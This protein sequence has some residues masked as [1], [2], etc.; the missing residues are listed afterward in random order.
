M[1][2]TQPVNASTGQLINPQQ[3]QDQGV[4]RFKN[5]S[6]HDMTLMEL[7][8]A[9]GN[10]SNAAFD[11]PF[12]V[13]MYFEVWVTNAGG[14][15]ED[16]TTRH[17]RALY[18]YPEQDANSNHSFSFAPYT[19][20]CMSS[21]QVIYAAPN[22]CPLA[23]WEQYMATRGPMS[24]AGM[25]YISDETRALLDCGP[26][27][28]LSPSDAIVNAQYPT[29]AELNRQMCYNY[30]QM[31]PQWSC[32]RNSGSDYELIAS[33]ASNVP[34]NTENIPYALDQL[35]NNC[36]RRFTSADANSLSDERNK[37][38]FLSSGIYIMASLLGASLICVVVLFVRLVS[39]QKRFR[40]DSERLLMGEEGEGKVNANRE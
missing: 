34:T 29:T 14:P 4:L 5:Y 28:V 8:N 1:K 18:G 36:V 2:T 15:S 19:M 31:C 37:V 40:L 13:T 39:I 16:P 30:R 27:V 9:M 17:I 21:T 23:D 26:E 33:A 10:Y 12:A 20:V 6:A 32:A 25:C 7:A 35:S 24:P 38:T 3:A 11:A 22:G